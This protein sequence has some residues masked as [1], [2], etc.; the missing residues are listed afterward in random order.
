MVGK[1]RM[2][3]KLMDLKHFWG[4]E[5]SKK[6][7]NTCLKGMHLL[8]KKILLWAVLFIRLLDEEAWL[9]FLKKVIIWQNVGG[10]VAELMRLAWWGGKIIQ[11]ARKSWAKESNGVRN[12]ITV[13]VSFPFVYSEKSAPTLVN[14]LPFAFILSHIHICRRWKEWGERISFRWWFHKFKIQAKDNHD[15]PKYWLILSLT[16]P[17][18][19]NQIPLSLTS[20]PVCSRG[21]P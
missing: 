2:W 17:Y 16:C 15:K 3:H 5:Q 1:G 12:N 8:R 18:S 14:S 6:L 19:F 21:A 11:D 7:R 20:N 10:I 4:L 13:A 9:H